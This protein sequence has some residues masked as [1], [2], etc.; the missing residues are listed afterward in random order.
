[1]AVHVLILTKIEGHHILI[2][3]KLVYK[4]CPCILSLISSVMGCSIMLLSC[5]NINDTY[6]FKN[7]LWLEFG[8]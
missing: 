4:L 6:C 5:R 1:M 8:S 3:C 7:S 2:K